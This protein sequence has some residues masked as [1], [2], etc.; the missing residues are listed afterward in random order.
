MNL[1]YLIKKQIAGVHFKKGN[2]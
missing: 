1:I 2:R